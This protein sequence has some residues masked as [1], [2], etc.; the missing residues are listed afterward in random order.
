[1]K[2]VAARRQALPEVSLRLVVEAG[3]GALPVDR[4]GLASL[5]AR[6]LTEGAAG[7]GA[8]EM[9]TRLDRIG[10][11][12]TV[13]SGYDVTVLSMHTLSGTLEEAL[14]FLASAVQ[15]PDFLDGEVERVRQERV[16]EIRRKEDEPA[17]RAAQ[18]LLEAVYGDHPFGALTIGTSERVAELD[19]HTIRSFHA[20]TYLPGGA[21]L[22]AC[23]H[24][25][26]DR[27]LELVDSRFS[28]WG[29]GAP[30]SAIPATVESSGAEEVLLIDRPGSQQS[31][32]RIGGIGIAR[33][34]TD[35]FDVRVLNA[36]LGGVFNS[37]LNMKLREEKGW[38]YGARTTFAMRRA[39]GPFVARTAVETAVTADAL[40]EMFRELKR[41][42]EE[43]PTQ[44]EM[45]L[46]INAL[47]LSLPR[48]FETVSQVTSKVVETVTYGLPDDYWPTFSDRVCAVDPEAVVQASRRYLDRA[49][50]TALV[51]G[52]AAVVAQPLERYGAVQLKAAT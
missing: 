1:M 18:G 10:A 45:R 39:A 12:F 22:V 51:V 36:I 16:D 19:A 4:A 50:L 25:E 48:K 24:V 17:H 14:D 9:A 2:V 21:A 47:T 46:A 34:A 44:E 28:G 3:A 8:A 52:D 43:L 29:R 41:M 40:A 38:T 37:R 13:S 20:S 30:D 23:G 42:S 49:R 5:T 32:L 11:S 6:L 7:V 26:Q 31:E 35:E 15:S 33:G 27:L